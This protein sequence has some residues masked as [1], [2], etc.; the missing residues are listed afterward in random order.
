MQYLDVITLNIWSVVISLL[1][2]LL[3]FLLLKKFLYKPVKGVLESRESEIDG[4]FDEAKRANDE[5]QAAKEQYESKL[6]GAYGE[7]EEIVSDA[8]TRAKAQ[9]QKLL[10]EAKTKAQ[11]I[12][13]AAESEA[14]AERMAA[15]EDIRA[16]IADVSAAIAEKLLEREINSSDKEKLIDDFIDGVGDEK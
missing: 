3:L 12:V 10:D 5:A 4:A 2:L 11:G 8:R 6:E 16:Q 1:N 7:A 15:R 9:E 14:E 13:R